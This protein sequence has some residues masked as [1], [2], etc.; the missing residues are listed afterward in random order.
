MAHPPRA[1]HPR[2]GG[3]GEMPAEPP[4]PSAAEGTR[5]CGAESIVPG[6]P[7]SPAEKLL[8]NTSSDGRHRRSNFSCPSLRALGAAV[9]PFLSCHSPPEQKLQKRGDREPQNP[10]AAAVTGLGA[11]RLGGRSCSSSS[12]PWREQRGGLSTGTEVWGVQ[13][14]WFAAAASTSPGFSSP[15]SFPPSSSSQHISMQL[16]A[17]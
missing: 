13:K 12:S 4:N 8:P 9:P 11:T 2:D 1:T 17:P 10:P 6:S 15:G 3:T 5:W 7:T 14:G 16:P